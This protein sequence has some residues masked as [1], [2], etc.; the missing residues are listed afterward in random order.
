MASIT[1]ICNQALLKIGGTPITSIS[2]PDGSRESMLCAALFDDTKAAVLEETNWAFAIRR[3]QLAPLADAPAFG[4]QYAFTL[5]PEVARVISVGTGNA[6]NNIE[7]HVEGKD[8]V[9]DSDAINVYAV[10][11]DVD[12]NDFSPMFTQAFIT[13]LAAEMAT[14][15]TG[16]KGL[17]QALWN[18]YG[19]K[20]ELA[21]TS[22]SQQGTYE[23]TS[24]GGLVGIRVLAS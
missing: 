12:T 18:E 23:K 21:T 22:D 6:P 7:W 24:L 13:R 14:A 10:V 9:C 20:I 16:D 1:S 4:Y 19:A 15:L 3:F 17:S 8:V 11:G 2:P 5:P